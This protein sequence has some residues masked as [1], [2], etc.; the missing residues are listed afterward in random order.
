[1]TSVTLLHVSTPGCI[2]TD[3]DK[4]KHIV[5]DTKLVII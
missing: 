2:F 1:M 5:Q 3:S 4:T